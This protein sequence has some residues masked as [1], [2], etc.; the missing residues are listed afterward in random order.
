LFE[1]SLE[2]RFAFRRSPFALLPNVEHPFIPYIS[3]SYRKRLGPW[4]LYRQS[5]EKLK[6]YKGKTWS[7]ELV[8]KVLS[9]RGS[10]VNS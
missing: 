2:G 3:L 5:Y 6:A 9:V 4:M 8:W 7:A 10:L 1:T